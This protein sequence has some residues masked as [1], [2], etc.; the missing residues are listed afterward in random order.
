MHSS[1]P[2]QAEF[3]THTPIM[4]PKGREED[5]ESELVLDEDEVDALSSLAPSEP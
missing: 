2:S 4:G 1:F 5:S 3:A